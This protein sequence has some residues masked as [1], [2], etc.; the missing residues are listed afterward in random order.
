MSEAVN[1]QRMRQELIEIYEKFLENPGDESI[2][3]KII[4]YDRNF[5]GLQ[6]YNDYLKSRPVPKDIEVAL[7]GLSMIYQYGLWEDDKE[8]EAFSDE[9]I[10]SEA[11]KI[12]EELR[13]S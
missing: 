13:K 6:V 10:V 1:F 9:K 11:K 12:L 2:Q 3:K 7:G 8:H 5:G 4:E